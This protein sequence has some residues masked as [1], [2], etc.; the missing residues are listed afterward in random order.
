M[1][2]AAISLDELGII[3][4]L[5]LGLLSLAG[6]FVDRGRKD[7]RLDE[8]EEEIDELQGKVEGLEQLKT[9]PATL[10]QISAQL[11]KMQGTIVAIDRD[12]RNSQSASAVQGELV[13]MLQAQ[14]EDLEHR[15]RALETRTPR[16]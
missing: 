12:M 15:I 2:L 4:A 6:H 3:L 8:A 11:E 13:K 7:Q 16:D 14:R 1:T 5:A 9:M 10:V